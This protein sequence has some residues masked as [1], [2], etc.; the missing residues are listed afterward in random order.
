MQLEICFHKLLTFFHFFCRRIPL[1]LSREKA[2]A[3]KKQE[4]EQVRGKI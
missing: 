2:A 1:P 3:A 4:E